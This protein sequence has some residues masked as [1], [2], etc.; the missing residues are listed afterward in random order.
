M[1][2]RVRH[3]MRA[4]WTG[5]LTLK[6][7]E[8]ARLIGSTPVSSGVSVDEHTALTIAAVWSA[9]ALIADDIASLP[10][11][12]YKRLPTGGK[13]RFESHR[14]YR[15]LHDAPNPEMTSMVARRTMQAHALMW[16]NGYAEIQRDGAGRAVGYWPLTPD[17]V[18]PWRDDRGAL[19][20]RVQNAGGRETRVDPENMIHIP[21]MGWDGIQGYSVIAKA[22]ESMGL[23]LAAERFGA[24]FFG[25]G[26]TFGGI[27]TYPEMK[28]SIT[29]LYLENN[30]KAIE[31]RHQGIDRAHRFLT[32]YG[33]AKYEKLGIPPNDAQFLETRVFQIRDVARWFKLPPHKLGDL[34]DATYSNVEQMDLAYFKSC[35]RPWLEL[36]EQELSRKLI[37]S[38]ERNQQFI[39]HVREGFLSA[40]TQG[41][42]EFY[43]KLFSV[44]AIT[45]NEIRD[46]E[47]LDPIPGGDTPFV[48]LNMMPL[49][50]ADEYISAQI[51]SMAAKAQTAAWQAERTAREAAERTAQEAE[52]RH[53]ETVAQWGAVQQAHAEVSTELD[54][55]RTMTATMVEATERDAWKLTAEQHETLRRAAEEARTT[56]ERTAQEAA[57]AVERWRLEAEAAQT[58]AEAARLEADAQARRWREQQREAV[59]ARRVIYGE[60]MARL[61]RREVAK[62]KQYQATAQKLR[63]WMETFYDQAEAEVWREALLPGI[64]LHLVA[65]GREH[66]GDPVALTEALVQDHFRQSQAGLTAVLEADDGYGDLLRRR[67]DRWVA[68]RAEQYAD[69]LVLEEVRA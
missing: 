6:S 44:G 31:A 37:P 20:Y 16:G 40:D 7:P 39:E 3:A 49:N 19:L 10:L 38:L 64:R 41:R 29:E 56:A 53:A 12:L 24:T 27:I 21:G 34:A 18:T 4:L 51:A 45:I 26:S 14:L 54:R 58:A 67:L 22:R 13:D 60:A 36:W 1:L 33:G 61:V 48:P 15:L 28:T 69:R 66:D 30:R 8:I 59:A 68:D 23:G 47:N 55:L 57:A 35:L 32:L 2:E 62:A 65:I 46:K 52:A 11:M 50:R 17:R 43:G 5:P 42:A 9:V 63:T 25:N